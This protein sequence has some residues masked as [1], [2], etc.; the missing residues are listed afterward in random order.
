LVETNAIGDDEEE[1]RKFDGKILWKNCVLRMYIAIYHISQAIS[2]PSLNSSSQPFFKPNQKSDFP[3][4]RL[5]K[6]YIGPIL[7]FKIDP[8]SYI[9]Y[10]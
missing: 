2:F 1:L 10:V 6:P 3:R 8:L 9:P 4:P 5:G 7:P